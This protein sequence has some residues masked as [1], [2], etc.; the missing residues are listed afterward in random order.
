MVATDFIHLQ[1]HAVRSKKKLAVLDSCEI[2]DVTWKFLTRLNDDILEIIQVAAIWCT[3][4]YSTG[5]VL[6]TV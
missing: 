5:T 3:V 6:D 4:S 1:F 2:A